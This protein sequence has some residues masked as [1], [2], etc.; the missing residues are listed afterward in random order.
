MKKAL[1]PALLVVSAAFAPLLRKAVEI[2]DRVS[3]AACKAAGPLFWHLWDELL[4]REIAAGSQPS[5]DIGEGSE[6][7]L[8]LRANIVVCIVFHIFLKH[9]L[10]GSLSVAEKH[11]TFLVSIP[12]GFIRRAT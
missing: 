4:D 7:R 5:T 11:E 6:W 1:I 2:P 12:R 10:D 8:E 9:T 3:G